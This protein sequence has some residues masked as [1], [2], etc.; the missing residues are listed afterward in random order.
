MAATYSKPTTIPRWADTGTRV[1]PSSGKQDTG[2]IFEEAPPYGWENWLQ[3][4]TGDW[5][6]WIDERFD[7]GP[8]KDSLMLISPGAGTDA[9]LIGD[10]LHL[11]YERVAIDP[12]A[13]NAT[14]IT[15][16]AKGMGHGGFFKGGATGAGVSCSAGSSNTRGALTLTEQNHPGSPSNGDMWYHTDRLFARVD[17]QTVQATP[18]W[19][20]IAISTGGTASI[21]QSVNVTSVEL[22]SSTTVIVT[23]GTAFGGG[24]SYAVHVTNNKDTDQFYTVIALGS[25]VVVYGWDLSTGAAISFNDG[26]ARRFAITVESTT[27]S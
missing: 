7:D 14:A 5:L 11:H 1:V 20:T 17:G 8:S 22:G 13:V 26:I 24:S 19:A 18:T 3:G 2:W 10:T 21:L 27:H 9:L 16:N 25:T 6:K 15:T 23:F 12:N 4:V